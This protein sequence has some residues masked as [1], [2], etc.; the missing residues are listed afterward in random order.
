MASLADFQSLTEASARRRRREQSIANQQ[1]MFYGQ[2]RG[3]RQLED[4]N[5]RYTE[6]INPLIAAFGRRGLVGP[7]VQSG[8]TR[9]ALAR[10]AESS[11]RQLGDETLAMQEQLNQIAM[12]EASQQ[13][14][15]E[16]YLTQLRLAKAQQIMNAATD[17]KSLISY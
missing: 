16:D 13:A 14:D 5:R 12:Q 11:Q 15:L 1:A 6:G 7:N 2:Q 8:I 17:I 9:N 3:Q 10:Y 4:I